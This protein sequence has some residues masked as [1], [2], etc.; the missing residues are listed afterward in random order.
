MAHL[1]EI[2][3]GTWEKF[4]NYAP[5]QYNPESQLCKKAMEVYEET[6]GEIMTPNGSS[7]R[8]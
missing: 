4:G 2:K 7:C 3:G 6:F 5:W 8:A 1:V